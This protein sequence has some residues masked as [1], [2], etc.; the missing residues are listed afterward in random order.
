MKIGLVIPSRYGSTRL[1]G[2]PLLP[3]AGEMLIQRVWR[4]AMAVTGLAEVV[5]ATDDDRI[6]AAVESFGG[7]AVRTS[8]DCANGTE[9]VFEALQSMSPDM[10][11]VINLQGDAVL[12]P[13][14]II[15]E[16][17]TALKSSG[18]DC[19]VTPAVAL[20][21]KE[22]RALV[23]EKK[24]GS[25]SG[26]LVVF[27]ANFRALYFSKSLIPYMR[28][29]PEGLAENALLPVHRHIGLYGYT[30]TVL[31]R[32]LELPAS[33]LET[34]EGLEQLRALENGISVQVVLVDY[35]G[36]SHA[37]ID[38]PEDVIQVEAII[39]AEGELV[40]CV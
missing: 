40:P 9:R 39:S 5:V 36:R 4:I 7:K 19:I 1:P 28:N 16:L 21:H 20:T 33:P 27:D 6:V 11:A 10:D 14:W 17:V 31:Q 12:T 13:P 38:N 15:E 3:I 26:T 2:K 29:M 24:N 8:P 23:Q 34:A 37:S 30:R 32:Y 35:R 18:E 22:Y 25:T